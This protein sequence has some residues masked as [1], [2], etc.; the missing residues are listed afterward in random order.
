MNKICSLVILVLIANLINACTP[1]PKPEFKIGKP[2][3]VEGVKYIP[4]IPKPDFQEVGRASWYGGSFHNRLT[5]NGELFN[6]NFLT[7]AHKT[8]PLPSIVTVTNIENGKKVNVRVNDRG[9]FVKGRVIDV[10]EA[11][12]KELGFYAQGSAKVMVEFNREESLKALDSVSISLEDREL[13]SNQLKSQVD[14]ASSSQK[15]TKSSS[16]QKEA[17]EKSE[18]KKAASQ[19]QV[20]SS[21]NQEGN[22]KWVPAE[23]VEEKNKPKSI[24]YAEALKQKNP[25]KEVTYDFNNKKTESIKWRAIQ[26][27][28]FSSKKKAEELLSKL[29]DYKN[30][31]IQE[32]QVNGV[33]F[34][35]VRVTGF[36]NLATANEAL[37]S[38]QNSGYK[39][40]FLTK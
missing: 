5:A 21:S 19:A 23:V 32:A 6:K 14:T 7:A 15:S 1:K 17:E 39:E 36:E 12:A 24:R 8:L 33:M 4:A 31:E 37:K 40:A 18:V 16:S 2:Y 13:I 3:S 27:G 35:R 38:L 25:E 9:P 22:K 29:S 11:A 28:A 30:A 26:L 34:Y 10:S 20:E